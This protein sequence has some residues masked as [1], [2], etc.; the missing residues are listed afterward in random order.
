MMDKDSQDALT[1]NLDPKRLSR[2]ARLPDWAKDFGLRVLVPDHGQDEHGQWLY[3]VQPS[4]EL[5]SSPDIVADFASEMGSIV[6]S[7]AQLLV[8]AGTLNEKQ[9]DTFAIIR[10][11][12]GAGAY[13]WPEL[14]FKFFEHAQP[15][16][17]NGADLLAWGYFIKEVVSK[18][19]HWTEEKDQALRDAS[20]E[21]LGFKSFNPRPVLTRPGL[22][23]LCYAHL[24]EQYGVSSNIS[25]D[26]FPRSRLLGPPGGHA[27]QAEMHLIQLKSG[28]RSFFYLVNDLGTAL[29]H[30]LITDGEVTLLPLPE[31]VP[32]ERHQLPYRYPQEAQHF[33]VRVGT[34]HPDR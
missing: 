1:T 32:P 26:I 16:L 28:E 15:F 9:V 25:I 27:A 10:R 12:H 13:S 21:T 20:G 6:A 30:F 23:A 4:M 5:A 24:V 17:S 29:E 33:M 34:P 2:T 19:R 31:L 22:V 14:V 3:G 11:E 7:S 18:I 8:R